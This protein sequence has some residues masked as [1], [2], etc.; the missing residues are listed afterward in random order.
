[1]GNFRRACSRGNSRPIVNN[2]DEVDA[3]FRA[4]QRRDPEVLSWES[5]DVA[6]IAEEKGRKGCASSELQLFSSEAL[7]TRE[8]VKLTACALH[9]ACTP[10]LTELL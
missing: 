2:R 7:L 6:G 9:G 4:S 5:N 3:T 8:N 1:L 10:L